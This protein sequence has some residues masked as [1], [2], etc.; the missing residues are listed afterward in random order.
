MHIFSFISIFN[1][2]I[3]IYDVYVYSVYISSSYFKVFPIWCQ[4]FKIKANDNNNR[5]G[6]VLDKYMKISKFLETWM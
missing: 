6:L 4:T 5:N 2:Y 3:F 1:I